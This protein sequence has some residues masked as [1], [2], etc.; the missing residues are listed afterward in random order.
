MFCKSKYVTQ[1]VNLGIGSSKQAILSETAKALWSFQSQDHS[2]P[3]R[4]SYCLG[5]YEDS[6]VI[7]YFAHLVSKVYSI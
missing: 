1:K 7:T 6:H 3:Y 2:W 4:I 5:K